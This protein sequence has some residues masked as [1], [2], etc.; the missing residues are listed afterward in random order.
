M[1]SARKQFSNRANARRSTGPKTAA[2]KA[3]AARNALRHGFARD[4]WAKGALRDAAQVS[5][6]EALALIIAGDGAIEGRLDRA[7]PVAGAQHDLSLVRHA[8]RALQEAAGSGM[9]AGDRAPAGS[10]LTR[11]ERIARLD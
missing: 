9:S 7:F 11:L 8:R 1:S 3:R 5:E 10:D 6:I 4:G 2:G